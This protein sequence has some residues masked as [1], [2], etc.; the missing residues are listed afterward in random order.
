[1]GEHVRNRAALLLLWLVPFAGFAQAPVAGHEL[2]ATD[3][4]TF[5]DGFM[6]VQLQQ[7][8]IA[9]AVIAIVKDGQVLLTKGYGY[10][11]VETKRPMTSETLVRIGSSA[12]LFTWT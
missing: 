8:N 5:L 10:A 2:T 11:D 4:E 3:L 6:P 9:G 12:K 1:M 7:S